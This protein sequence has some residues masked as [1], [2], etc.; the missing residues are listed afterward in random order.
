VTTTRRGWWPA[1]EPALL[2]FTVVVWGSL[3]LLAASS[4]SLPDSGRHCDTPGSEKWK[5]AG[6]FH[7]TFDDGLDDDGADD[8]GFDDIR[9]EH[10]SLR[11]PADARL[12]DCAHSPDLDIP[13]RA[14]RAPA[15]WS[16]G[17]SHNPRQTSSDDSA[18]E[19]DDDDGFEKSTATA[20]SRDSFDNVGIEHPSLGASCHLG[21]SDQAHSL[22]RSIGDYTSGTPAWTTGES[23]SHR[24]NSTDDDIDDD[25]DDDGSD[26][27][28]AARNS[29]DSFDAVRLEHPALR[30]PFHPGHSHA[31][32]GYIAYHASET[33]TARGAQRHR[34]NSSDD[35]VDSDSDDDAAGTGQLLRRSSPASDGRQPWILIVSEFDKPFSFTSAGH[36]LRAP[37]HSLPKKRGL[38]IRC[39]VSI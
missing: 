18:D 15:A 7:D 37:P 21:Q 17:E 16:R 9:L 36:S 14:F 11:D 24:Q 38:V 1:L 33:W 19:D 8:D 25:D 12:L 29:H 20:N 4:A 3:S 32:D 31:L 27:W 39:L 35:N 22:N 5:A 23:Q 10:P 6:N 26:E 34:Q 2:V 30:D 28:A 13:S